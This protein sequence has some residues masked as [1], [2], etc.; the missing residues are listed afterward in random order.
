MKTATRRGAAYSM[1]GVSQPISDI[2]DPAPWYRIVT[3]L[4]I[5]GHVARR[6]ADDFEAP[7]DTELAK[8]VTAELL[9][10]QSLGILLD[11]S[12][13]IEN[14]RQ[15]CAQRRSGHQNIGTRSSLIRSAKSGGIDLRNTI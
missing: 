1:I 5:F 13:G 4:D 11:L 10:A 6:F 2:C 3:Q 9:E 8:L 7:L 15:A 14:V 12:D